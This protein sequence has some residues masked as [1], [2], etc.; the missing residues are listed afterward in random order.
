MKQ[1]TD[2]AQ[3]SSHQSPQVDDFTFTHRRKAYFHRSKNGIGSPRNGEAQGAKNILWA[4]P[5]IPVVRA[6]WKLWTLYAEDEGAWEAI[7]DDPFHMR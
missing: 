6:P 3:S 7:Y 5:F 2:L 4:P 1:A